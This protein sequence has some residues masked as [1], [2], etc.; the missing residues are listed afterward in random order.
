MG[1]LGRMNDIVRSNL[2]ELVSK[3]ENPEKLLKQAILQEAI[4]GKLTAPIMRFYLL[5]AK[6]RRQKMLLW[7]AWKKR[8][9]VSR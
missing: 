4:Q 6:N 5:T 7:Q 3:A 2:N 1:V 8:L 9:Q